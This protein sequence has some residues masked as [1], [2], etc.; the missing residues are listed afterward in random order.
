MRRGTGD[1]LLLV[2]GNGVDHRLLLELDDA[3]ASD[4]GAWE[5]IYVDLP[6]FGRTTALGGTGGLADLAD[7]LHT[8][9]TEMVGETPFAVVGSSMGGLLA[10]NLASRRPEHCLGLALLAPVIETRHG[11]R[12]RPGADVREDLAL[13]ASLDPADAEEYAAVA[14]DQGPDGWERFRRAA[15]PGLRC[16][17]REAARRLGAAYALSAPDPERFAFPVVV[18]AGRQDTIVG[19]EDQGAWARRAPRATF[20]ELDR[21]GHNVHLDRPDAVRALLV[22]WSSRVRRG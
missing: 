8:W 3:F 18:V 4:E 22:D 13:L 12:T 11:R 15:L 16:G 5:R 9:V 21:A 6:G 7:W 2:H 20:A 14:V 1:P 17:D 10:A 19:F